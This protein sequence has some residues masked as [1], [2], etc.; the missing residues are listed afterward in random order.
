MPDSPSCP[1]CHRL[2]ELDD[3]E[4]LA[5]D[6]ADDDASLHL[7]ICP[8]CLELSVL[9]FEDGT[10]LARDL[11]EEEVDSFSAEDCEAVTVWRQTLIEQTGRW[12]VVF[13]PNKEN[14]NCLVSAYGPF[15]T[16][17]VEGQVQ[18]KIRSGASLVAS[19]ACPPDER[20]LREA[21]LEEDP[22]SAML[23]FAACVDL[24]DETGKI[25]LEWLE[26]LS[27]TTGLVEAEA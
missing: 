27:R 18:E 2:L 1:T 17:E 3:E 20:S 10:L 5:D 23:G 16:E 11:T 4:D 8:T 19:W 21:L 22:K 24:Y 15:T 6:V 14:Q 13:L 26:M 7:V 12:L 9:E 25:D